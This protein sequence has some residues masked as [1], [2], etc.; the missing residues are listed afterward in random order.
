[1]GLEYKQQWYGNLKSSRNR[2]CATW[3]FYLL[4][5]GAP[6][7]N[8]IIFGWRPLPE[9]RAPIIACGWGSATGA[10]S[11]VTSVAVAK[12]CYYA[13]MQKENISK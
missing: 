3:L 7:T 2:I 12:D 8:P 1:M 6:H 4:V 11:Q 5:C 13:G 10:P 9:K